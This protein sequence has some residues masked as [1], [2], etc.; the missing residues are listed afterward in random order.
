MR[1][2]SEEAENLFLGFGRRFNLLAK[3]KSLGDG[4]V[5]VLYDRQAGLD[6]SIWMC[7][8]NVDEIS[9]RVGDF[10]GGSAFPCPEAFGD[11]KE[12][13]DGIISGEYRIRYGWFGSVLEEEL[14]GQWRV[15]SRYSGPRWNGFRFQ[16]FVNRSH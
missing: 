4:G 1:A 16:T 11:F 2:L 15:K 14:D 8:D 9:Y 7:F 5:Y 12:L 6:E 10:Y 13:V 3:R